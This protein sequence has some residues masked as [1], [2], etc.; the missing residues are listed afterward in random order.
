MVIPEDEIRAVDRP[1]QDTEPEPPPGYSR[2]SLLR[3]RAWQIPLVLLVLIGVSFLLFPR[4]RKLIDFHLDRGRTQDA[5]EEIDSMLAGDP[6]NPELLQLAADTHLLQG[7]MAAAI[8]MQKKAVAA[9]PRDLNAWKRLARFYE[10][11]RNP[12]EALQAYEHIASQDPTDRQAWEKV[13]A[14]ARSFGRTDLEGRAV[15]RLLEIEKASEVPEDPLLAE[16]GQSLETLGEERLSHDPDILLDELLARLYLVQSDYR[17]T[18]KG[19]GFPTALQTQ[20]A[21]D[22]LLVFLETG[23]LDEGRDFA[24]RLDRHLD[25]GVP[26]QRAWVDL[27]RWN[28]LPDLALAVLLEILEQDPQNA[29]LVRLVTDLSGQTGDVRRQIQS[30]ELQL[31]LE[32]G[33]EQIQTALANLY[34][35]TGRPEQAFRLYEDLLR[36]HPGNAAFLDALLATA[37]ES[38]D[39]AL[40][41]QAADEAGHVQPQGTALLRRRADLYLAAESPQKA[42]PLLS[43]LAARSGGDP[44]AV[45]ALIETAG[46]T[47]DPALLKQALTQ[48]LALRPRDPALHREAA[49]AFLWLD[50]PVRAY[51]TQR[52]IVLGPGATR[53]DVF[54]LIELAL[55]TNRPELEREALTLAAH[56]LQ[57]LEATVLRKSASL[58]RVP[59]SDDEV[60]DGIR[61]YLKRYP[62]DRA[63]QDLLI[64]L[65]L[66]SGRPG[67]AAPLLADSSDRTP[68]DIQKALRA[69]DAFLEADQLK[70]SLPYFERARDLDPDNEALSRRL[71]TYYGWLGLRE[72]RI[73]EMMLLEEKGLLAPEDRMELAQ[74]FLDRQEGARALEILQTVE[75]R[76][77][78]PAKEGLLLASAYE[79]TGKKEQA[80]A[81]YR[82]LARAH[83]D[84]PDLLAEMGDRALWLDRLPAALGFYEAAL[85]LDP[86]NLRALKGSGQIY[87]WNNNADRAIARFEAYNRLNPDDF[88]VRYQ[89][90]EIYFA[91]QREGSAFREYR[92]TLRL[93]DQ[94]KREGVSPPASP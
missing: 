8:R 9:A 70:K 28:G 42:Q 46:Y 68:R 41:I 5:L 66:E 24:R 15:A 12:K 76:D 2:L 39:S 58:P 78:I 27:L 13:I 89:L 53:K 49:N 60:V 56:R 38:N 45:R 17:E 40:K 91:N 37:E 85:R 47:D 14:Y 33:S 21:R 79:M 92:K 59:A 83:Q 10:W 62:E 87:A 16:L 44:E 94:V 6:E 22:A 54:R 23:H 50:G 71:V 65:F 35:G 25:S 11:D 69:A 34:R 80:L 93:L 74:A 26:F 3:F 73:D 64:R 82:R 81:V 57:G 51:Q 19:K 75:K 84:N 29:E 63:F 43:V 67:R 86:K 88:E 4:E 20:S 90:G 72:K 7:D 52:G 1:G 36:S 61:D 55:A 77:P 48:A 31:R 18:R 30:L 32:P